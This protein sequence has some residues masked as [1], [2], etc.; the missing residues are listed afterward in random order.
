M[1]WGID[2]IN[3]AAARISAQDWAVTTIAAM[4]PSALLAMVIGGLWICIWRRSWRAYGMAGVALGL[5]YETRFT[6]VLAVQPFTDR[7]GGEAAADQVE[8]IVARDLRSSDRFKLIDSIPSAL[9]KESVDYA[10]WDRL[11]AVWL[12][13]GQVEGAGGNFT[14]ILQVH[15]V[16][17]KRLKETGRFP[18]PN[19]TSPGFRMAVHRASDE[20]VRWVFGEPGMAASRI[21][22]S[23]RAQ[24][25]GPKEVYVV[26]SD[27]ENLQRVTSHGDI[28][29]SPAWSPDASRLAFSSTKS[30][31]FK[32]GRAHV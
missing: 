27:G 6:P 2:V 4:P 13:T 18:I 30:G 5:V 11:G 29:L 24:G 22:F 25:T 3:E 7:F 1:G 31:Q 20:V 23:M 21:A 10:L 28:A 12:L 17:Y 15:D 9:V 19:P 32:I 26:D 8:A 16:V 14:L